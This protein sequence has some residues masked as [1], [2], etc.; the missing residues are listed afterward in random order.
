MKKIIISLLLV[1]APISLFAQFKVKSNGTTLAGSSTYR[2][3]C[4][5]SAMVNL[6]SYSYISG[7]QD[8]VGLQGSAYMGSPSSGNKAVGVFGIAGNGSAGHNMG[9]A[10]YLGGSNNGAA[11]F[12]T[13][14]DNMNITIPGMYAGYFNGILYATGAAY[15]SSFNTISDLRLKKNVVSAKDNE[16]DY[17]FLD[18]VLDMNVIEYNL[19]DHVN[20]EKSRDG[21]N[22][23]IEDQRH[24]GLA[25]QELQELF[26]DLV[27][28]GQDGYLAVN[29]VELVPVLI[30]SIQ[31]LK[32]ELDAVKGVKGTEEAQKAPSASGIDNS[33]ASA[34]NVLYQNTPNPFKEQ[35]VIRFRLA[36]DVQDAAICIFDM[37]GKTIKKL[38]ISSGMESVS[39]GGYEL[40]EGMFLYSLIVNGQEID[41]KKMVT[42]K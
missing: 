15:A 4:F 19:I 37:T 21:K 13:T 8:L 5:S 24:I 34:K 39:I 38:P 12:G 7:G 3:S 22:V 28:E 16:G 11:I 14:Y 29:Y 1:A 42:T 35:T 32:E 41:T 25:A 26:P 33:K 27:V 2:Q 6:E 17:R 31:E 20:G 40:G 30:R 10:G 36:D 18:R 23:S 9:V